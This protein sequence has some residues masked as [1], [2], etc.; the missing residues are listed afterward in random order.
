MFIDKTLYEIINILVNAKK[1]YSV[2]KLS[3]KVNKSRRI[4]YYN[5]EKLNIL[6]KKNGVDEIKNTRD[7]GIL[8]N[9]EQKRLIISFFSD[10]KYI[11]NKIERE[12][13]IALLIA[14]NHEK[15]TL[16]KLTKI[17]FVSKNSILKNI[18]NIKN[19][20]KKF[21]DK[22]YLKTGK[23]GGY[24]FQAP[25]LIQVQFI[26]YILK[27]IYKLS[28]KK[29]LNFLYQI[30]KDKNIVFSKEFTEFLVEKVD[31]FEK[32]LGKKMISKELDS[33][34]FAFPY[35]YL[36][37]KK[38]KNNELEGNLELLK[39]RLEFKILS[40][41]SKDFEEKYDI[42][43]ERRVLLLFSL[44]FLC[45]RKISDIHNSSK[46]YVSQKNIA[47]NL[48]NN[49]EKETNLKIADKDLA[50]DN[51]I[52]YLKVL[53]F[54]KKYN[55][56]SFDID[57]E[58]VKKEHNYI[59][60]IMKKICKKELVDFTEFEIANICMYFASFINND[61]KKILIV[62][63]EID[64]IKKYIYFKIINTIANIEI[65]DVI[66]KQYIN[67]YLN[68]NIFLV[69]TTEIDLICP[70]DIIVVDSIFNHTNLLNI[71]NF[72]NNKNFE[73]VIK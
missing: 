62:S 26:Y 18:K 31:F 64:V 46:D 38:T 25:S 16:E 24:Y 3:R 20:S 67:N 56:I 35:L 39:E 10:K 66:E 59:F 51:L 48:I 58:L 68:E 45:S 19:I 47:I 70:F 32:K 7:E 14:T 57:F 23:S 42:K 15:Q 11:L 40:D 13:A 17:F 44:I 27:E 65:V 4:I 41:I 73:H 71:F 43:I 5:I 30:Y 8:L 36:F 72:I 29:F 55:I 34:I 33:F 28:N 9:F 37:M 49:F 52:T 63:N 1:G 12:F 2:S 60:S 22:I 21:N 54:R 69:I 6:L 61:K 53:I 50:I